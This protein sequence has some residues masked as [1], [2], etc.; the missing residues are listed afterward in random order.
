MSMIVALMG[1]P[2]GHSV[3]PA[4]QQAAFDQLGINA[5]YETWE[6]PEAELAAAVKRLRGESVL[7]ANVTIPYKEKVIPLLDEVSETAERIGAVNTVV[8]RG[9]LLM[10]F[11]TDAEGFVASLL[12]DAGYR[13]RN[14]KV[15]LLGAGGAARA[16]LF[17]LLNEE[18]TSI[19]VCN[20]STERARVL[21]R[22]FSRSAGR[23]PLAVVAWED[24]AGSVALKDCN[25]VVNCTSMGL[26][27]GGAE[28]GSPLAAADIPKD[29]MV[30]D[31]VYNPE[32]TPL[33]R[34]ARRAGA[35]AL[36]GLGMLVRQGAAAFELW[37]GQTAPVD[38][39][40]AKAREA[41]R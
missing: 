20:R 7:G 11:N 15:V 8:N 21:V 13:L 3:S 2:L 24:L 35:E 1:Y 36:G 26:K 6:V 31:L 29:A 5:R 39:M 17:A 14:R 25:L 27:S 10:G 32:E 41:L 18:V 34:E 4:F 16:A 37:T 22:S 19:S 40:M 38:I 12:E 33:L 30:F 28:G 9:G 23:I